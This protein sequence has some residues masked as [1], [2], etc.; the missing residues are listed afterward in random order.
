MLLRLLVDGKLFTPTV[1]LAHVLG[2][3]VVPVNVDSGDEEVVDE[4]D[5][6]DRTIAAAGSGFTYELDDDDAFFM[7]CKLTA[8]TSRDDESLGSSGEP[9]VVEATAAGDGDAVVV[10][11]DD[12]D[13]TVLG[14]AV[15]F[16][17]NL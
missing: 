8:S 1:E 7:S 6:F 15:D 11:V 10:V 3:L 9:A 2:A 14:E 4:I 13:A 12:D 17:C 16:K 5:A